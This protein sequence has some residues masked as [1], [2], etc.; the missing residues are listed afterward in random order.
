M[1]RAAMFVLLLGGLFMSGWT[2]YKKDFH[3]QRGGSVRLVHGRELALIELTAAGTTEAAAKSAI[4]TYADT[5]LRNFRDIR[6]VYANDTVYCL[7]VRKGGGTFHLA[8]P[9][10]SPADGPC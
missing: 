3:T 6:V 7:E 1:T 2:L 5:D 4:G 8:G 9:D 10:S